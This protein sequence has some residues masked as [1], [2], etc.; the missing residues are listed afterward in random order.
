MNRIISLMFSPWPLMHEAVQGALV[1]QQRNILPQRESSSS[2]RASRKSCEVPR[3]SAGE[4]L[5]KE[6]AQH[7]KEGNSVVYDQPEV[8]MQH[9]EICTAICAQHLWWQEPSVRNITCSHG[10]WTDATGRDVNEMKC[11]MSRHMLAIASGLLL[12][13]F[14][15]VWAFV[16][17]GPVYPSRSAAPPLKLESGPSLFIIRD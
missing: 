10:F 5:C 2:T 14:I 9:G 11:K 3:W 12:V 8:M 13:A 6:A 15:S 1:F 7:S 4:Y 17:H 16:L